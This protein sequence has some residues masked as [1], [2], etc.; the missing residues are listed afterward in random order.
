MF[1]CVCLEEDKVDIWIFHSHYQRDHLAL[2]SGC[3]L[4]MWRMQING[5]NSDKGMGGEKINNT[6]QKLKNERETKIKKAHARHFLKY[7]NG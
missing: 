1:I 4:Q 3:I 7:L 2:A 5:D 6:L